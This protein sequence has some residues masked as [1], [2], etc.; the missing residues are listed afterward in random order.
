MKK[1]IYLMCVA[2]LT[3]VTL[4]SCVKDDLYDTPHPDTGAV[5]VT[6][7]WSDKSSDAVLPARYTLSINDI[8]QETQS[9]KTVFN[10]L[11][12][13]GKYTLKVFNNSDGIAV[14]GQNIQ[15][16]NTS[17]GFIEPLPGYVFALL[18]EIDVQADD[19]LRVTAQ[20]HQFV[21]KLEVELTATSGDY[22][23]VTTATATFSGAA[24]TADIVSGERSN[25]A[26]VMTEFT[27]SGNKFTTFF[28]LL[29]TVTSEKL[30]LT[31]DITFSNGDKQQIVSDVTDILKDFN[32]SVEPAKLTGNL[33]L[34]VGAGVTGATITDWNEADGGNADAN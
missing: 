10:Q 4:I 11:L 27:K 7:D 22:E 25:P 21:R 12:F 9:N 8:E 31:V 34:P 19:T 16:N 13:P 15:V 24:S 30:L 14:N 28:R 18:R 17:A 6:A 5:V 1:H 29:G 2:T 23:R 33:L 26:Q 20:M 32:N 3:A